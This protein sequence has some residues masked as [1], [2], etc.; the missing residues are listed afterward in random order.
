MGEPGSDTGTSAWGP[1]GFGPEGWEQRQNPRTARSPTLPARAVPGTL[2]T[3]ANDT[4]RHVLPNRRLQS[5]IRQLSLASDVSN[6]CGLA[7]VTTG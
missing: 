5:L 1:A 2:S 6:L 3:A 4:Q 7:H